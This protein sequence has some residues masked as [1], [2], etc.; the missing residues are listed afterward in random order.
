MTATVAAL[1]LVL[2]ACGGE[3]KGTEG[4]ATTDTTAAAPAAGGENAAAP[5]ATGAT[6]NVEMTMVN[7]QPRYVPAEIEVKPGD[8]IVFKNGEGGPHNVSFWGDSIPSGAAQALQSGMPDQ[9]EPLHG[10]LLVE[11]GATYTIT[12]P[13]AA[14]EGEYKFYCLPHLAMGMKGEMK[15]KK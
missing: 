14:P 12:I 4:T 2:A 9:T 8:Q 15:V 5:A 1:A 13:A 10:P 3:K 11:N 6:H 7:G